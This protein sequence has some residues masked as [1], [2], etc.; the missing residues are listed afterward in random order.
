M[1]A[2]ESGGRKRLAFVIE[3]AILDFGEAE[4]DKGPP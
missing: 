1:A 4:T 3:I 2:E